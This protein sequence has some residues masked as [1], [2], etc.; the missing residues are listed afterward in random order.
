MVDGL[1]GK[2]L[3]LASVYNLKRRVAAYIKW[4]EEV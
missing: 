4:L 2:L 1:A 3:D